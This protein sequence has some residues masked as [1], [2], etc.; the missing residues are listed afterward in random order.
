MPAKNS[1]KVY[2]TNGIYHIYNRGVEKRNIF[3]DEQDY[4]IFLYYLKSYLSSPNQQSRPPYNIN[5]C[6]S[7]Y[8]L[9][10]KIKLLAYCLMPNHFHFMLQQF[11]ETAMTEFM[12]RFSNA[13]VKY[14]NEKYQRVGP[15]F[16]GPYKAVLIDKEPYYL[17]LTRYIHRNPLEIIKIKKSLFNDLLDY[18][19]SSYPDHCGKRNT[20]WIYKDEILDIAASHYPLNSADHY[21]NNGDNGNGAD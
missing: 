7:N 15:L 21:H 5:R 6:F 10:K 1:L 8:D 3:C 18:P 4:K 16:Q 12:K 2:I 19:Y 13:Y 20:V 14:F 11:T 9:Y 17:H